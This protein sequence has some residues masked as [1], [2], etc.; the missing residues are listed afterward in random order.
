VDENRLINLSEHAFCALM[1][2]IQAKGDQYIVEVDIFDELFADILIFVGNQNYRLSRELIGS[3]AVC[4]SSRLSTRIQ[5]IGFR[6]DW[7]RTQ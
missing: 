4:L 5:N 3:I 1:K 2:V 7:I 6:G